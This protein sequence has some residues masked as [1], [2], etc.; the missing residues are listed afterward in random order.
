MNNREKIL[1]SLA[2]IK[3]EPAT[4]LMFGFDKLATQLH[5][6]LINPSTVTP[7]VIA[8]HGEWGSGKTSLIDVIYEKTKQLIDCICSRSWRK[9][10]DLGTDLTYFENISYFSRH[11]VNRYN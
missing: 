5:N 9:F 1:K 2:L 7:F 6:V 11:D 3:D 4:D 10:P 8:I